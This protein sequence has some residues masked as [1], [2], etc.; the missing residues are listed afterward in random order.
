M[1]QR[2]S[3]IMKSTRSGPIRLSDITQ[4]AQRRLS[5]VDPERESKLFRFGKQLLNTFSRSAKEIFLG[6]GG[7]KVGS[8]I[9]AKALNR[10]LKANGIKPPSLLETRKRVQQAM[11]G[12]LKEIIPEFKIDPA[13]TVGE[14]A[15]DI[16]AGVAGFVTELAVMKKTIPG[17][18]GAK[19]WE[20]QNLAS[21]GTPG[22]GAL[23]YGVFNL[24]GKAI[25]GVSI[26]AKAGRLGAES[27]LLGGLSAAHQKI[28][29]GEIDATEVLISAGIPIGLKAAGGAKGILNR[30]LK[31]KN[32]KVIK[33]LKEQGIDPFVAAMDI[34]KPVPF[35]KKEAA[36]VVGAAFKLKDGTIIKGKIGSSH[37]HLLKKIPKDAVVIDNGF[38]DN[39]GKYLF[40]DAVLKPGTTTQAETNQVL[41]KWSKTAKVL[42]ATQVKAALSRLRS[43]QAARGTEATVAERGSFREKFRAG[44]RAMKGAAQKPTVTPP[45]LTEAQWEGLRKRIETLYPESNPK[46]HFQR[47][48]SDTVLNKLE[49]GQIPTNYDFGFLEKIIGYD[50][51]LKLHEALAPQRT[52]SL[53]DVPRLSRDLLKTT[54]GWDPQVIRQFSGVTARHPAVTAE[55][56]RANKQAYVGRSV[57]RRTGRKII[58][59]SAEGLETGDA[60]ARR[61]NEQVVN[62]PGHKLAKR[63]LKFLGSKPWSSIEEGTKLRQYG[64]ASEFLLSRKSK[65]LQ[66]W[67]KGLAA[68]ERGAN[69][70]INL[71]VQR[72]W[73][74]GEK[75]LALL[76]SRKPM[77]KSQI[78]QW[79]ANRAKDILTGIK[80][81]TATTKQT[82]EI[83]RAANWILFSP[84][85]TWSRLI[86]PLSVVKRLST[87][88]GISGRTYAAQI[89]IS[90]IAKISAMG[91]IGA[92]T[93]H[94]L[95][96]NDPTKEPVIDGSNDPT[97][98]MWGKT[99]VGNDT[100]DPSG[101]DAST[102]RLFAR[103]GVSAYMYGR[104]Q[105]TGRQGTS[106]KAGEEFKRWL[107]SR[108]TVLLGLGKSLATGKDW[109][110]NDIGRVDALLKAFPLEF[111]VSVIEAGGADGTWESLAE[112]DIS[113]ASKT[114]IS[115]IPIGALGALGVGTQTYPVKAATT[116]SKFRNIIAEKQHGKKWDDLTKIEQTQLSIRNRKQFA[117]LDRRVKAERIEKP[118]NPQRIIEEERQS[119]KR[120]TKMLSKSNR[121][122][123]VGVSVG[124]SRRPKNF[125]LNDERYQKY[126]ERT[127]KYLNERLSKLNLEGKSD[128]VRDKL[129]EVAVKIAKNKAYRDVRKL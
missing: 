6:I 63:Y 49:A 9:M 120:I 41:E 33:A 19:L 72:L 17:L 57:L 58:G 104:E 109:L 70:G 85:N 87:G 129:L 107:N 56:I 99:R 4:P 1:A 79:R 45:N 43:T 117:V 115:N 77:S 123:I 11:R 127:A 37:F 5:E 32:P 59:K 24:P 51:T 35:S 101:G 110:G 22:I 91:S 30:A 13:S 65:I 16:A 97:N 114:L 44:R 96:A 78:H 39:K 8:F 100:F 126:Q 18:S 105:L 118:F 14:K 122:K 93:G 34:D 69:S 26:A 60:A 76:M 80:R 124:V 40:R 103:L 10:K 73:D 27:A 102:Y 38:V 119:A 47:M 36:N 86:Q 53:V 95:R 42:N 89:M 50:S 82:K 88:K 52:Y 66:A 61:I 98:S 75:D 92:Y 64:G 23:T 111:I 31:A 81:R 62:M 68:S 112:G 3:D 2:L 113:E 121:A 71:G 108:E 125:F 116:R 29:T 84:A 67:G 12:E 46:L 7:E 74:L 15:T 94:R 83:E 20:A 28:E 21:G 106:P 128:R 25:K 55:A 54:F 90:N 48:A